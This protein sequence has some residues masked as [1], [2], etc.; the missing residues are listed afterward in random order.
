MEADE[1]EENKTY[2]S[3][4]NKFWLSVAF[5]IPIFLIA[6]SDMIPNNPIYD[7]ISLKYWNWVQFGISIPAVFYA[8]W[9]FFER[10]YRSIKTWNLNM[11]TLIGIGAG[12]AWVFSVFYSIVS[13]F[14]PGTIFNGIRNGSCLF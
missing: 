10:A 6:M 8:T 4:L 14:L 12:V 1:S 9:I 3:L 5:T 11:F 2:K 13:E 7:L